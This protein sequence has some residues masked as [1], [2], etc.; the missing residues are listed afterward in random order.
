MNKYL[1]RFAQFLGMVVLIFALATLA[2][3]LTRDEGRIA[4]IWPI[5]AIALVIVLRSPR[6]ASLTILSGFACG[7]I[8]TNLYSGD[9]LLR[10]SMLTLANTIEVLTAALVFAFGSRPKLISLP[11]IL[12]LF[13]A[14]LA[15]CAVSTP[16]AAA[17]LAMT[18]VQLPVSEAAVWFA[19]DS[20]GI[21]LFVPLLW[22]ISVKSA[23]FR[24]YRPSFRFA[25]EFLLVCSVAFGVFA[26]SEY[27]LL[28]LV[29][30]VLVI[31][32]FSNGIKAS[33]LG[34]LGITMIALPLTLV[35]KGP[36][37][38]ME[39]DMT[40]RVLV[41]QLFLAANSIL[42]LAVGAIV[43]DRS[44]VIQQLRRSTNSLKKRAL[45]KR[46]L[47][48]KARLAEKMSGVG[49]WSLDPATS[50]VYWSPQ[51][52]E[53][54]GVTADDFDP[55]Y[56]D[57]VAFYTDEDRPM[58]EEFVQRGIESGKGWEFEATI[59]TPAGERRNVRSLGECLK[60]DAGNVESIFGVFK[61]VTEEKRLY[62][63]LA[64]R[65]SQYRM[66]A[67]H[68][69][70]IVLQTTKGGKI[71]YAS[72]SCRRLGVSPKEAVGMSTVEFVVPEDREF[73]IRIGRENFTGK[74]PDPDI[75]RE[76]RVRDGEG[77]I[78]W[79]EGNPTVIRDENGKAVSVINT[80]RDVT[81]RREREDALAAARREAEAA[82][83]AKSD[84][85]SNMS[86]E[87]RTP[88]NGILGFTKLVSETELNAEQADYL[89]NIRSAG[90]MLREI[91]DDI[92]DFSKVEAGRIELDNQPFS[93]NDAMEDVVSLV[94]A[95]RGRKSTVLAQHVYADSPVY[96]NADETRLRQILTNLVGNAAKFT[97]SGRVDVNARIVGDQLEIAVRDTGPGIPADK[98]DRVFEGFRQADSTITR[99]YGG[100]GLGLS[101]SRSLAQL[102]GGSLTLEST[103]GEGTTVTLTLPYDA[104]EPAV[105][106]SRASMTGHGDEPDMPAR[107][108]VVDDVEMNL[109]LIRHGLKHTS[110]EVLTYT[111][112]TAAL[113]ELESGAAFDLIFMDVQMPDIDG[114]SATRRIR[115]MKGPVSQTPIVALT[116]HA[117]P[118][119]IREC[120]DAGMDEHFPK[121]VDLDRMKGLIRRM[122]NA[123]AKDDTTAEP[124]Q[125][126]MMA[127]LQNEY[128]TYLASIH[129]EFD[130]ILEHGKDTT[131]AQ[132][133]A[134]L[135][136]A[137]A[138]TAGSFGF[139]DVSKAAFD[140]ENRALEEARQT[141]PDVESLRQKVD[142]FVLA[143]QKAAAA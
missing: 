88:L 127:S 98:L 117:L 3:S 25:G 143:S 140:L 21:I 91:V 54:H 16:L 59:V 122:L 58:V 84:F 2:I 63:E 52:Y 82:T 78:I 61:D 135:A 22:S 19:A 90:T 26:Q 76:Y 126:D 73:A 50:S 121:P 17:S 29:P 101:I 93:L 9:S 87:I 123:P 20:L 27:P 105:V 39:T 129:E 64:R 60:D 51:V 81:E 120:L 139:D 99:R 86:H 104:A 43:A 28:F 96:I 4:A 44:R 74:K 30:P 13:G 72:P 71:I 45:A 18:G 62:E 111:S 131:A 109:S 49:H 142:E 115:A 46:E 7:L 57:A 1:V 132:S 141:R 118:S 134:S 124:A 75:R 69:T 31:L 83:E 112:A 102:M 106:K 35:G 92:L 80:L 11:G 8:A 119:H 48:G 42:A 5:N 34:L 65:E 67:E 113:A 47:I 14:A 68:S 23:R 133:V 79:L 103:V 95:A 66:L 138:G 136:H 125:D 89:D 55:N 36:T 110:Y 53:I 24:L 137:I 10:A 130:A 108:M 33:A 41:L 40:S 100:S 77:R 85:L 116:A 56:G 15:A 128:R 114:L 97:E 6:G 70:D 107:I 94:E 12:K 38:L 32:A 37:A